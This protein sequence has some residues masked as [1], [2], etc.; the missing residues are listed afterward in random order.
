MNSAP[1]I[2][3]LPEWESGRIVGRRKWNPDKHCEYPS[4]CVWNTTQEGLAEGTLFNGHSESLALLLWRE[5]V[6]QKTH[7]LPE[8]RCS[9]LETSPAANLKS[10]VYSTLP[11]EPSNRNLH[12]QT[13]RFTLSRVHKQTHTRWRSILN[14]LDLHNRAGTVACGKQRD[15]NVF[16]LSRKQWTRRLKTISW[17]GHGWWA[18]CVKGTTPGFYLSRC[19]VD[20][21]NLSWALQLQGNLKHDRKA[22]LFTE[23]ESK[24][25]IKILSRIKHIK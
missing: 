21:R 6:T 17:W 16:F 2:I 8:C 18:T 10:P 14:G 12:T 7:R 4:L 5:T 20:Q 23:E 22:K 11:W 19:L 25:S 13:H 15:H 1:N 24:P 9:I 3:N